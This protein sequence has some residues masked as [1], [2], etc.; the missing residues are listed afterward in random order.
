MKNTILSFSIIISMILFQSHVFAIGNE[1]KKKVNRQKSDKE[2]LK[3]SVNDFVGTE[4]CGEEENISFEVPKSGAN[5]KLSNE[6]KQSAEFS[7]ER[8]KQ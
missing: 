8:N 4:D 1:S 6:Q 2:L 7:P 3:F 5:E